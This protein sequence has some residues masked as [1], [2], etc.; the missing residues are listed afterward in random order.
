MFISNLLK[1]ETKLENIKNN[2]IGANSL[3][4]QLFKKETEKEKLC[5]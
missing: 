1:I 5:N 2:G 4:V 3:R